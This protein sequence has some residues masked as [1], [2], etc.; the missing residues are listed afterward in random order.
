MTVNHVNLDDLDPESPEFE[1]AVAAADAEEIAATNAA[2][3]E[4]DSIPEPT[5]PDPREPLEEQIQ[6]P[7]GETTG[8]DAAKKDEVPPPVDAK[9]EKPAEPPK[10]DDQAPPAA[11]TK[12]PEKREAPVSGVASKDGSVVLP[13]EVLK[14]ARHETKVEREK[15]LAAEAEALALKEELARLRGGKA[16][17]ADETLTKEELE[18]AAQFN[19]KLGKALTR[20]QE[21]EQ[22]NEQLRAKAAPTPPAKTPEQQAAEDVQEA[23]DQVPLLAS[24]QATDRE[25]FDRAV[26][27]DKVTARSPKWK[28]K[29][30]TERFEHVARLV[31]E[32]YD[33]EMPEPVAARAPAPVAKPP[34]PPRKDPAQ[35]IANAPAVASDTLSDFKGGDTRHD[36]RIEKMSPLKQEAALSSMSDEDFERY[37]R[38]LA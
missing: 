32:E 7:P 16:A 10:A 38:K 21:L 1:A 23:I 17:P 30:Y 29:P 28:G 37:L 4:P 9:T 5:I 36:A 31:A 6:T 33:V 20:A 25:K 11:E 34:A 35:V 22:E 2:R 27:L 19:P 18:E 14:G 8:S 12:P 3:P 24:W 26:E 13:Y 15:R